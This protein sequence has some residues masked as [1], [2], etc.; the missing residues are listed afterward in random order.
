MRN[1]GY[2]LVQTVERWIPQARKRVDL[3]GIGDILCVGA[4]VVMVQ[5]TSYSNISSHVRKITGSPA[6]PIL[7]K[8]GIGILVHGWRKRCGRWIVREVDVS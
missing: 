2:P 3:F 5:T 6:L 8:A 7:R 1:R 4:D